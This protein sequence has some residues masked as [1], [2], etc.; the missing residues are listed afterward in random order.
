MRRYGLRL[1][2]LVV[3]ILLLAA[4]PTFGLPPYYVSLFTQVFILGIAAA[5]LDLLVGQTGVVSFAHASFFGVGAYTVAILCTRYGINGYILTLTAA[6][7]M[8]AAVAALFGLVA[9]RAEG[10]GFLIIT[11]ALNQIVWGLA[12]QWVA[13]TGGE[14]GITGFFRPAIGPFDTNNASY[15]RYALA[16]MLVSMAVM[17]VVSHSPFGLVLLGIR[18]RPRRMRALGYNIWAYQYAAFLIAALFA[19]LAG[20]L[21]AYYNAFAS[22]ADLALPLS[23]QMLI[24]VILG[25]AGTLFGPLLGAAILIFLSNT[26][27]SLT[28][29]WPTILGIVYVAIVMYAPEGLLGIAQKRLLP[30]LNAWLRLRRREEVS[31]ARELESPGGAAQRAARPESVQRGESI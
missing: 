8:A 5:A 16:A 15:Y 29:R 6:A 11:L 13:V 4:L 30:A 18:E 19:G 1:S 7:A 26:F 31:A 22:P 14:N 21:F 17:W 27:S 25:G 10:V 12:Y 3:G 28:E 24:M 2:A 20:G 9:L 23:T